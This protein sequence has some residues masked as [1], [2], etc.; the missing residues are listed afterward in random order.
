MFNE[1]ISL[2]FMIIQRYT[3]HNNCAEIF[4]AK[5]ITHEKK[6]VFDSFVQLIYS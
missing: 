4:C 6:Y 5:N 3:V 2:K 1:H